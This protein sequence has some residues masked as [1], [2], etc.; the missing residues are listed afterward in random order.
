MLLDR[1][2]TEFYGKLKVIALTLYMNYLK[3]IFRWAF[4]KPKDHKVNLNSSLAIFVTSENS[5]IFEALHLDID[6]Y[7]FAYA[8]L[9]CTALFFIIITYRSCTTYGYL[10]GILVRCFLKP[11]DM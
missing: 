11:S 7:S 6:L 3:L 9:Y 8:I 5:L 2:D 4:V 1:S 10:Q